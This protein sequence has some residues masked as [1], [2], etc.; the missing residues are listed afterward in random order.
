MR[1]L[2]AMILLLALSF[3]GLAQAA[4]FPSPAAPN[5]GLCCCETTA[6]AW[7][8]INPPTGWVYMPPGTGAR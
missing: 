2:I 5:S 6:Y 3:S 7:V 8:F 4:S 1:L